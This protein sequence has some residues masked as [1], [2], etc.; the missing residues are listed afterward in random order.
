MHCG[1]N[2]KKIPLYSR[3]LGAQAEAFTR[4]F[5]PAFIFIPRPSSFILHPCSQS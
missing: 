5:T 2:A 3:V 1:V 4:L